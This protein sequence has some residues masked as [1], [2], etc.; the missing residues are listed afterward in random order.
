[1]KQ[2]THAVRYINNWDGEGDIETVLA[3]KIDDEFYCFDTNRKLI[4]YVGDEILNVWYLDINSS[5]RHSE[6]R[7]LEDIVKFLVAFDDEPLF[8][9]PVDS[10]FG[11]EEFVKKTF[12]QYDEVRVVRVVYRAI[13]T[14]P[15]F[16][17]TK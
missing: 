4:E 6:E 15:F 2:P 13:D 3:F 8:E 17:K 14:T 1:M 7:V 16:V 11:A 9:I 5:N 10:Y 12:K